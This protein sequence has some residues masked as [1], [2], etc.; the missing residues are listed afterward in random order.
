MTPTNQDKLYALTACAGKNI[1]NGN[2][3]KAL[4]DVN[5]M[6]HFITEQDIEKA[7]GITTTLAATENEIHG[8][9]HHFNAYKMSIENP[10]GTPAKLIDLDNLTHDEALFMLAVLIGGNLRGIYDC[11]DDDERAKAAKNVNE[12]LNMIARVVTKD[13]WDKAKAMSQRD[14]PEDPF[15]SFS[16]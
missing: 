12:L 4:S 7:A 16:A 13:D 1:K 5:L 3:D 9:E 14:K 6:A 11:T 15:K 10:H 2:I 8:V